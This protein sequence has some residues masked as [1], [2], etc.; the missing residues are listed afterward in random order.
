[1]LTWKTAKHTDICQVDGV[2]RDPVRVRALLR[3]LARKVDESRM[4]PAAKLVV[5][6]AADGYAYDRP[7]GVSVA[8]LSTLGP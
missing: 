2:A 6:T 4:G 1:M 3:S 8:P 5:V 7:D